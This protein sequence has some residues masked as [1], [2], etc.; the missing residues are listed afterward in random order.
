[1]STQQ[2]IISFEIATARQKLRSWVNEHKDLNA[3]IEDHSGH[4][5]QYKML[6]SQRVNPKSTAITKSARLPDLTTLQVNAIQAF[7][8]DFT[9]MYGAIIIRTKRGFTSFTYILEKER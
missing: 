3:Y 8:K 1:M 2:N 4:V 7:I 6:I 5:G 9:Q